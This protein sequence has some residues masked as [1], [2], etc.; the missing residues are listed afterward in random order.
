MPA[1]AQSDLLR[2][3]QVWP[4]LDISIKVGERVAL[5]GV[6]QRRFS[7]DLPRPATWLMGVDVNITLN[8]HVVIAPS[9]YHYRTAGN[10]GHGRAPIVAITAKATWHGF[11]VEDR[12]R[13]IGFLSTGDNLWAYGNRVRVEHGIGSVSGN[14][15]LFAWDEAFYFSSGSLRNRFTIGFHRS[16][17]KTTAVELYY[18]RQNDHRR[19]GD[20]N[21]LGIAIQFRLR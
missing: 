14:L 4:E 2:S 18:L 13:L 6:L 11:R 21:T 5:T 1:T 12:N 19:W 15:F 8:A 3:Q 7:T 10:G 17:H 20:L 9:Y 16:L